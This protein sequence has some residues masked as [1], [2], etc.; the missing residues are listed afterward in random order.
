MVHEVEAESAH[1]GRLE[2]E[3]LMHPAFDQVWNACGYAGSSLYDDE[4]QWMG[5]RM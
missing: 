2:I 3:Q 1:L 5:S 4:G